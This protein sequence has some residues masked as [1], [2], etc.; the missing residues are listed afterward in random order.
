MN[1]SWLEDYFIIGCLIVC[2][3]AIIF[4]NQFF[5][6]N[7]EISPDESAYLTQAKIFASGHLTIPSPEHKDFFDAFGMLNNGRYY[8]KYPPGWPLF[9]SIGLLIDSP[10]IINL[11]FALGTIIIVYLIARKLFSVSVARISAAL[12]SIN[13]FFLF[14]SA[15]YFSHSSCLFFWVL[16]V[17]F[18]LF[19]RENKKIV[20]FGLIGATIGVVFSIRELDAVALGFGLLLDYGYLIYMKQIKW[21]EVKKH[22]LI[23]ILCIMPFFILHFMNNYHLTGNLL[24]SPFEQYDKR[25][26]LGFNLIFTPLKAMESNIY[27]RLIMLN[28]WIPFSGFIILFFLIYPKK[29][30]R[31]LLGIFF[32]MI[33]AYM[34]YPGQG[35]FGYGVRYWY[36]ASFIIF[37]LI[38]EFIEQFKGKKKFFI[39]FAI[40]ITSIIFYIVAGMQLHE[41][42]NTKNEIYKV[43]SE[44]KISNA[45]VF[46]DCVQCGGIASPKDFTF[47]YLKENNSVLYAIDLKDRNKELMDSYSQRK[48]YKWSCRQTDSIY[49]HQITGTYIIK[50]KLCSLIELENNS[51]IY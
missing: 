11:F 13:A 25:D 7:T 6:T 23:F 35:G 34:I 12:M 40:A 33:F 45:I 49:A 26:S 36:S 48:F 43:I 28:A 1:K 41:Q 18:Y 20:Y 37:I 38:G 24:L 27:E 9:L 14:N 51:R 30:I 50:E 19:A 29:N 21:K 32:P 8:S 4:T 16:A 3:I 10:M 31:F 39:I 2:S 22:A 15:S 46:L 5:I 42:I 44:K 47:N 17:Y